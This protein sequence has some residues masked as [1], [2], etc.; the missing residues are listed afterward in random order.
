MNI[1]DL[2]QLP[3]RNTDRE[4]GFYQK[5]NEIVYWNGKELQCE[6]KKRKTRCKECGG[7][8]ICEHGS[9]KSDCVKC[10]GASICEH[11]SRRIRCKT[12]MGSQI[13]EHKKERYRC[14]ICNK[15]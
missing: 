15:N 9:R 12:C 6:H 5:N 2:K 13:C 7:A 3:T 14:K 11:G 10:G 4:T 1:Q 8:S